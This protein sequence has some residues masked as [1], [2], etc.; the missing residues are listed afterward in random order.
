MYTEFIHPFRSLAMTLK[1]WGTASSRIIVSI[2]EIVKALAMT[3]KE[4]SWASFVSNQ[5]VF[6]MGGLLRRPFRKADL[7]LAM[8][9]TVKRQY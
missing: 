2:S 6:G 9:A 8:T 3:L 1:E 7:L 5:L 4:R